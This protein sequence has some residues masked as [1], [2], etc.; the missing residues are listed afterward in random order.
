MQNQEDF[1][2]LEFVQKEHDGQNSS[3]RTE[4]ISGEKV[5]VSS[6]LD[7]LTGWLI[8]VETPVSTAMK[9]AYSLIGL[10]V[11]MFIIAIIVV[12][13]L[14]GIFS[15]SFTKP[16]VNLSSVIKTISDGELKDFDISINRDDEIGQLYNSFKTMTKNLRDLVGSIQTVSTSLAAQSQ[17]LFRATDESTQTLTQV[18]TTINEMAQG[19]SD[20]AM[21]LQGTTDAIKEVNNIVSNATEKTVIAADKAKESINLAMAGQKALERQS[22]KIEEINKYTNS[23]GDSIQELAAMA[24][25]I[26]NII[27]VINFRSNKPSF[28][29]CIN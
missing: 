8:V 23:V 4:N 11:I 22:Q 1:S 21:M 9:S 17:Q 20:Q 24:D 10:S 5:I 27:G 19:N 15:N 3:M 12:I 7:D 28:L 18:V 26:H 2:V 25:E 16:L 14:G 29:K 6:C 13:F